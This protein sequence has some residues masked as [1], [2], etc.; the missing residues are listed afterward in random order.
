MY[1]V[2]SKCTMKPI[3]TAPSSAILELGG[4]SVAAGFPNPCE[5]Y[6][7][8]RISLDSLL[9]KRPNS[10]F[11]F[12]VAGN[13]MSPDI[14]DGSIIVVDRSISAKSGRI[15]L[16]TLDNE[17]VVKELQL[18]GNK[19]IFI[20]RNKA[21]PSIE[22]QTDEDNNWDTHCIWGVVTGVVKVF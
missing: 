5:D 2:Y 21:F 3:Q 9:I 12:K 11:L 6:L 20:S 14:T 18:K 8:E 17:F 4:F 10:T 1:T 19:A 7:S 13:S 15:V 22:V 16:A